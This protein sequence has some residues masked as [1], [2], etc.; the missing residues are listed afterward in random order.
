MITDDEYQQAITSQ[1]N[2]RDN[3]RAKWTYDP[4][5]MRNTEVQAEM[6]SRR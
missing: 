3:L 4:I 1:L 6:E 2:F 5:D